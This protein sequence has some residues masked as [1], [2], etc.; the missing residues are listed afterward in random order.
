MLAISIILLLSLVTGML[1]FPSARSMT[2]PP[3]SL[4][5][6]AINGTEIVL[7]GNAIG[8]LTSI[9]AMGGY[10]KKTGAVTGPDLY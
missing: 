1:L 8:N 4:T 3:M 10:R 5:L 7:D 9:Q 6:V 2:L